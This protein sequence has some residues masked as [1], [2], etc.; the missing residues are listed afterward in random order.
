VPQFGVKVGKEGN[1]RNDVKHGLFSRPVEAFY[2][3]VFLLSLAIAVATGLLAVKALT[4][5]MPSIMIIL[6][7]AQPT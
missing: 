5:A 1:G 4:T 2:L 7:T 3:G 6:S